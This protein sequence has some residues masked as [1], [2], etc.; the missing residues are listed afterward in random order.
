MDRE[1][2]DVVQVLT[3]LLAGTQMAMAHVFT[4]LHHEGI[5]DS[6]RAADGLEKSAARLPPQHQLAAGILRSTAAVVRQQKTPDQKRQALRLLSR[7]KSVEP[8][9]EPDPTIEE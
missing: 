8:G 9:S 2:T 5:L 1:E 6:E 4:V 7:S 3:E